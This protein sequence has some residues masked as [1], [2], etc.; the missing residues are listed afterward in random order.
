[1]QEAWDGVCS[2]WG[3]QKFW[4]N[5][6]AYFTGFP[7]AALWSS[8]SVTLLK[9][10]RTRSK[11]FRLL[12]SIEFSPD[13]SS[14]YSWPILVEIGGQGHSFIPIL[15]QT[16][17][18]HEGGSKEQA[19]MNQPPCKGTRNSQIL[20]MFFSPCS[21]IYESNNSWPFIWS[22]QQKNQN[23]AAGCCPAG[24]SVHSH[25]LHMIKEPLFGGLLWDY[26][27]GEYP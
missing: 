4:L 10:S 2:S 17:G 21:A 5:Q 11:V 19:L 24:Y 3:S 9:A 26:T 25:Y 6:P 1:M 8:K 7:R 27:Y 12:T 13:C 20:F 18:V 22:S 15:F 23:Q 16:V 14:L